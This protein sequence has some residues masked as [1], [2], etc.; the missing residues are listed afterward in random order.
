MV[1]VAPPLLG[2]ASGPEAGLALI[3]RRIEFISE[4]RAAEVLAWLS[5]LFRVNDVRYAAAGGLAARA[6]GATRPLVDL[7]FFVDGGDLDRLAADLCALH[8]PIP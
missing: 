7:D 8:R 6:W 2:D 3:E 4:D 1:L 5:D